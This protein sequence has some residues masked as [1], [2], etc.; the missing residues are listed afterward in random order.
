MDAKNL[1]NSR[2]ADLVLKRYHLIAEVSEIPGAAIDSDNVTIDLS[3]MG[4]GAS[5]KTA[6]FG[7]EVATV[8]V[9]DQVATLD[10]TSAV[11]AD[12]IID[13]VFDLVL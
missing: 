6:R 13:V 8:T 2:L 4:E 1:K 12:D 5:V 10:F 9:V 7:A 3:E 11:A